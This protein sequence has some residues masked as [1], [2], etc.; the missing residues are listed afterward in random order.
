MST[1]EGSRNAAT[2]VVILASL[3]FSRLPTNLSHRVL[4]PILKVRWTKGLTWQDYN[5][6]G[7]HAQAGHYNTEP[8]WAC[9]MNGH[10]IQERE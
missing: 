10:M 5:S 3:R 6:K 2:T 4:S 8:V 9:A 1:R 7:V